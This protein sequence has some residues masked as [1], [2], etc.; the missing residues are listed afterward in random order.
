[1]TEDPRPDGVVLVD[2]GAQDVAAI[3][4]AITPFV[5]R[6]DV[7]DAP[8]PLA[9]LAD[10]LANAGTG[11]VLVAPTSA[12]GLSEDDVAVLLEGAGP[13]GVMAT[14]GVRDLP[15]LGLWPRAKAVEVAAAWRHGG[16]LTLVAAGLPR[17]RLPLR[18]FGRDPA[19][20]APR[21]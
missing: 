8:T 1:M 9:G 16:S 20:I 15:T 18:V 3:V 17:V 11:F 5:R 14:D 10:A 6:V 19:P 12:V 4:A 7:V 21:R 2:G 13:R